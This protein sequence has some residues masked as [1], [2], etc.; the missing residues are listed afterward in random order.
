MPTSN[1]SATRS[2]ELDS[3]PAE[4]SGL[5]VEFPEDPMPRFDQEP[6]TYAGG[7]DE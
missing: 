6:G 3:G 4:E 2:G 1:C 5:T 7:P